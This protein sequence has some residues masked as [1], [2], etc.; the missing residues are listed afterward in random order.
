MHGMLGNLRIQTKGD[1]DAKG[2]VLCSPLNWRRSGESRQKYD[3]GRSPVPVWH[4]K[5][6]QIG[7]VGVGNGELV[8]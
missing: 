3:T 2:Q 4:P 7:H 8:T 5:I 1:P 6:R